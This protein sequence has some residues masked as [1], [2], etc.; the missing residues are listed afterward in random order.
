MMGML[1][2]EDL[3]TI[4]RDAG[5]TRDPLGKPVTAYVD[6]ATVDGRLE[7]VT[8]AEGE[9]FVVDKWRAFMPMGTDLRAGDRV[10]AR[11]V[12]Y[13]VQGTP[14]VERIPGFAALSNVA[15]FLRYVGPVAP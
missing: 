5:T 3:F 12:R 10:R 15:A 9:A 4:E 11:G 13:E 7:Q 14:S 6:V 8:S 1:F 2:E